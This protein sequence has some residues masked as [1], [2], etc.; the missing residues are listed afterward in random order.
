MSVMETEIAEMSNE[1]VKIIKANVGKKSYTYTAGNYYDMKEFNKTFDMIVSKLEGAY[2][3]VDRESKSVIKYGD[4]VIDLSL[5]IGD[6]FDGIY[7]FFFYNV[8][9]V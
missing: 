7:N 6:P 4:Y 2:V 5:S 1:I 3:K 9:E 8:G